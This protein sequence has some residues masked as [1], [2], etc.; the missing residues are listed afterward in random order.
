LQLEAT[1]K[2]QND[3][4][5]SDLSQLEGIWRPLADAGDVARDWADKLHP[6]QHGEIRRLFGSST[7]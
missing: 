6:G 7:A 5:T 2:A 3:T 1:H 4:D